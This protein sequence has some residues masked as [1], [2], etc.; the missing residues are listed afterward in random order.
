V[1]DYAAI[2]QPVSGVTPLQST[3]HAARPKCGAM[4]QRLIAAMLAA[5]AASSA[6]AA[7][8]ELG[9]IVGRATDSDDTDIVRLT[10]RRPLGADGTRPWWW[11]QQL[12]FGASVW[13]VPDLGGITRRYDLNVTPV[14]RKES[15]FGYVEAGIGAYLLSHTINNDNDRLPSSFQFGSHIGAGLRLGESGQTRVGVAL[16]HLSN[17]GIKQ[18]NGGINLYQLT[19]SVGL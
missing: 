10:Y 14:W 17:A 3:R 18:P 8:P 15:G 9:L 4:K 16:Q 19:L 2:S 13:R 6:A 1:A 5:G 11:P 12:Q 7:Q